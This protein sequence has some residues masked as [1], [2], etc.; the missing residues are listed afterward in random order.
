MTSATLPSLLLLLFQR[1]TVRRLVIGGTLSEYTGTYP[2]L[3]HFIYIVPLPGLAACECVIVW[4][5]SRAGFT[6]RVLTTMLF[7]STNN[8]STKTVTE[9]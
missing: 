3:S 8:N 7:I 6:V 4:E 5:T 1:R 9:E 2:K